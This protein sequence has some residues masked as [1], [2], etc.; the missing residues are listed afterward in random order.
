VAPRV[1][2]FVGYPNVYKSAKKAFHGECAPRWA[3]QIDPLKLGELI[4][5]RGP[6]ARELTE[7]R[8]YR[9]RPDSARDPK[10][11]TANMRQSEAQMRAGGGR[12]IVITR[13]LRYPPDWP[14]PMLRRRA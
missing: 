2:V 14:L 5:S 12:V 1:V 11:Y 10:T 8:V 6:V 13:T 4:A 9:G 7:V 3:G